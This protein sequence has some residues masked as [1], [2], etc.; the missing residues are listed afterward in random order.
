MPPISLSAEISDLDKLLSAFD[1]IKSITSINSLLEAFGLDNLPAAH[2]YGLFFGCLTFIL[3]VSTVLFLLVFGGSFTRIKQQ[4]EG[5]TSSIPSSLE[6]RKDRPLLYESLL[7]ARKRMIA[8][9][10]SDSMVNDERTVLMK[11][12][13][14]VA[15][16]ITGATELRAALIEEEE[17]SNDKKKTSTK[18]NEMGKKKEEL[19]NSYQKVTKQI[20]SQHTESVRINLEVKHCRESLRQGTRLTHALSPVVGY[21]HIPPIVV[22]TPVF[23][24][25]FH[26]ERMKLNV[27]LINIG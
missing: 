10:E 9:Y 14:N 21:I 19:K 6:V 1:M 12:L 11:L 15:P 2:K 18:T 22:H 20:M 26:A 27:N 13:N 5:G 23:M 25:Q 8:S 4:S 16:D 3:T 17:E 24:K 7:E